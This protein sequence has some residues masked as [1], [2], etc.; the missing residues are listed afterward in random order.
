MTVQIID[1]CPATSAF[2]YCKTNI[3]ANQRCG[4]GTTDQLDIDQAA[5]L[6]LTGVATVNLHFGAS[7]YPR[8]PNYQWRNLL[9]YHGISFNIPASDYGLLPLR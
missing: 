2:N 3:P 9:Y 7:R 1:S 5:Y 8:M 6:G 4:D